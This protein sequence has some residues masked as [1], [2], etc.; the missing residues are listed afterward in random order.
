MS[1]RDRS[2]TQSLRAY[3]RRI[4]CGARHAG[5]GGVRVWRFLKRLAQLLV[6]SFGFWGGVAGELD[7]AIAFAGMIVVYLG[8]EGVEV[9]LATVGEGVTINVTSDD[10]QERD[11][12]PDGGAVIADTPDEDPRER[13][14]E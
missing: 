13:D 8:V 1:H 3:N 14:R 9:A 10:E 5:L 11:R 2:P 4:D 12:E 6:I 7:P